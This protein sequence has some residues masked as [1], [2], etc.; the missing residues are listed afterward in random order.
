MMQVVKLRIGEHDEHELNCKNRSICC[1]WDCGDNK[2]IDAPTV[3][4][5]LHTF[6]QALQS[7]LYCSF[8]ASSKYTTSCLCR[9]VTYRLGNDMKCMKYSNTHHRHFISAFRRI[10]LGFTTGADMARSL[11]EVRG[12]WKHCI[13]LAIEDR[14]QCVFG[15]FSLTSRFFQ[16]QRNWHFLWVCW[17]IRP[18]RRRSKIVGS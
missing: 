17:K 16:T 11:V 8:S 4:E 7:L 13:S 12:C 5:K 10:L 6:P 15:F 2:L 9:K 18:G 1:G 3:W 14:C